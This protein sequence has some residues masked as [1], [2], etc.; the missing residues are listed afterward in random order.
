MLLVLLGLL[1]LVVVGR[2]MVRLLLRDLVVQ[3]AGEWGG[4]TGFRLGCASTL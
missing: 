2:E 1:L 4:G 3:R